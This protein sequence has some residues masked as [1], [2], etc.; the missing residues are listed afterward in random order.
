M[1][2]FDTLIES[3]YKS[4]ITETPQQAAQ[5]KGQQADPNTQA[6]AVAIQ[7]LQKAQKLPG[8]VTPQDIAFAKK[9]LS[10]SQG[11][12]RATQQKMNSAAQSTQQG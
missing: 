9:S 7:T 2:N 5:M 12:T 10:D 3:I 11:R 4:L 8:S 6:A 1:S